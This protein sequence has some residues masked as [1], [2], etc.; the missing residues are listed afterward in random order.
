MQGV[1]GVG[2]LK[3]LP[4]AS[5]SLLLL[6]RVPCC[7]RRCCC[8]RCCCCCGTLSAQLNLMLQANGDDEGGAEGGRGRGQRPAPELEDTGVVGER[9]MGK[10]GQRWEREGEGASLAL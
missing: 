2:A 4:C 5:Q 3:S 8:C 1:G 9:A 6:H 7:C 10:G